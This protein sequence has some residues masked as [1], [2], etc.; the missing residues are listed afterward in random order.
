MKSLNQALTAIYESNTNKVLWQLSKEGEKSSH[1]GEI[2]K[3][4]KRVDIWAETLK[5][6]GL[7]KPRA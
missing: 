5:I 1:L 3:D 6:D 4:F 7:C 2:K